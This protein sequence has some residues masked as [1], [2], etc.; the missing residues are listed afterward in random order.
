VITI[1][2]TVAAAIARNPLAID[3]IALM[4]TA[5]GDVS[6]ARSLISPATMAATT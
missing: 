6:V 1:A 4:A 5:A 2:S 3:W